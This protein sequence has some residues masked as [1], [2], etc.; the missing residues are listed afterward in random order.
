M[1]EGESDDKSKCESKGEMDEKSVGD[2][3]NEV[4]K[5]VNEAVE[6]ETAVYYMLK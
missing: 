2:S 3:Q 5:K 1:S 4:V 6:G